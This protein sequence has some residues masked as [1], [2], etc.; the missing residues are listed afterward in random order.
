M[1][2]TVIADASHCPNT[3]AAGYGYWAV[4]ERAKYGGGGEMRDPVDSSSA[5]EMMALANGLFYALRHLIAQP[6]DHVLLQ[7]DCQ[8]AI[9]AFESKRTSLTKHEWVAK[10]ELFNLKKK[11][12]ITVSFGH[13]KGHTDRTEARYVTNVLCDKR[14]K[15]GMRTARKRIQESTK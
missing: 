4:S 14:A 11:H 1:R 5:A 3:G 10:K 7:T 6:G 2:V 12:K 13:V 8:A 15:T 9:D